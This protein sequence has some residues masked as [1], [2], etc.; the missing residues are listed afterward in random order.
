MADDTLHISS[1]LVRAAP[2]R[3]AQ[4]IA[5][6][7]KI[8]NSEIALQDASGKIIVTLETHSEA[9]IV[10]SLTQL[11]LLDGVAS[12]ALIYHQAESADAAGLPLEH[13]T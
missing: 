4:V 1:A 6:I 5:E 13:Q 8:P 7:G 11:Q 12:A 10:D 9:E 2:D 3:M